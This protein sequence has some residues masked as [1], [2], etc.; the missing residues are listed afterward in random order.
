[1]FSFSVSEVDQQQINPVEVSLT[2]SDPSPD[3]SRNQ[4]LPPELSNKII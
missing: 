2:D 4:A 1:M 3:D